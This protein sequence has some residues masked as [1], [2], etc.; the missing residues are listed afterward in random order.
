M[1]FALTPEQTDLAANERSWLA[2]NDP[3]TVRRPRID[4]EPASVDRGALQH[5]VESGFIGLLGED[6]GGTHVDLLVLVE[7]HGRAA[8]SAPLAELALTA[9]FASRIGAVGAAIADKLV[10]G[11]EFFTPVVASPEGSFLLASVTGQILHLSG[12]S[13]PGPGRSAA[14]GFLALADLD[15]GRLVAGIVPR[16]APGVT[17]HPLGT[18]DLT[19]DWTTVEL[20]IELAEDH[21]S[22][23]DRAAGEKLIDAMALYRVVD[24]LGAADRLLNETVE[25]AVA[26]TQFGQAIGSFQAVKHHCANMAVAV[27]SSRAATWAAAVALDG[28]DPVTR[29][30][31]VSAAAAHVGTAASQAAQLALQVHGGIGFTWEHDLHLFLRRIE[32]DEALD[33]SAAYHRRRLIMDRLVQS[34]R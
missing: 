1:D 9:A 30:R 7:E 31:A 23:I 11:D 2:K 26:R 10:E 34:D 12:T 18:L 3:I 32:V 33:G 28:S 14:T 22:V 16:D 29:R 8:S 15:D 5:L 21:W 13:A 6:V 24:A 20:N 17:V 25:Y 27:E 19:R 4:A